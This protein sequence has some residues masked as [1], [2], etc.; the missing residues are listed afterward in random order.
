MP[1]EMNE[2][3]IEVEPNYELSSM[4]KAYMTLNYPFFSTSSRRG[5]MTREAA[6][7]QVGMRD[8]ERAWR[9]I[10]DS[11]SAAEIRQEFT[12]WSDIQRARYLATLP[13]RG[14]DDDPIEPGRGVEEV[15]PSWYRHVCADLAEHEDIMVNDSEDPRKISRATITRTDNLWPNESVRSSLTYVL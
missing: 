11:T 6:L 7:R 13:S 5:N 2:E 4:D 14:A 8:T 15:V 1:K 3:R 10:M 12:D 9:T